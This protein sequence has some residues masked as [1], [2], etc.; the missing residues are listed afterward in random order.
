MA[1]AASRLGLTPSRIPLAISYTAEGDGM[2]CMRCG[3]CDGYACFLQAKNDLATM[4]I[5]GLMR[6]GMELRPNTIA[7]RLIRSGSVI[8][9][10]ECINRETGARET[11]TAPNVILAAG[12]LATPHL[13][14]TSGLQNSNPAGDTIG[15]YLTRH[16][17]AVVFGAF[18]RRPNPHQEFDKHIAILDFYDEAGCIQQLTPAEGL[19]RAYMPR[20]LRTP[21]AIFLSH[22]SGLLVIAED[23]P[24]PENRVTLDE[25]RRDR[26]GMPSLAVRHAYTPRDEE[27]ARL[28]V[29]HAKRVLREAGA[30]FTLVHPIETWSHALGTVRMGND[31][32]R[33]PLDAQGRFRGLDNLYVVDG[34]ALPRSASLNPSLTISA[35]A[36]R[37]AALI[38][39][40]TSDIQERP[41]RAL[42][43]WHSQPVLKTH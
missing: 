35:N 4:L 16:R 12:A 26:F 40:S 13:L 30:K 23:Q 3:R 34:S 22:A 27:V 24:R 9:T 17:N 29:T 20:L 32:T 7:V 1:D 15:R 6:Q 39:H 42:P 18:A 41:A 43:V 28:L 33:S 37:V 8:D 19:V 14:L 31:P 25:S 38:A 5:P 11:F 2:A 21:A 36:L 10:V